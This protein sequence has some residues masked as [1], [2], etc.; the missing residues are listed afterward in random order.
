MSPSMVMEMNSK[1]NAINNH[2][3]QSNRHHIRN[4]WPSVGG[5]LP[6]GKP[7]EPALGSLPPIIQKPS[8]Y[9]GQATSYT[10]TKPVPR[11]IDEKNSNNKN[12]SYYNK[13][14]QPQPNLMTATN[15]AGSPLEFY[16]NHYNPQHLNYFQRPVAAVATNRWCPPLSPQ[17]QSSRFYHPDPTIMFNQVRQITLSIMFDFL[18]DIRS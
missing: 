18:N 8:D 2:M 12:L 11:P 5:G 4:L 1:T 15:V 10:Q 7:I 6:G 17:M 3:S 13:S 16:S 9:Y 14:S